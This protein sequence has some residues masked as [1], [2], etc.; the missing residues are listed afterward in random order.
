VGSRETDPGGSGGGDYI[1]ENNAEEK[2]SKKIRVFGKVRTGKKKRE[3]STM[4]G[5]GKRTHK[6]ESLFGVTEGGEK[7]GAMETGAAKGGIS[8]EKTQSR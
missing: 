8:E 4:A 2:I 3:T 6:K 1:C 7:P 5:G